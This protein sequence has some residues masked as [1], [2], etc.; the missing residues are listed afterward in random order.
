[1]ESVFDIKNVVSVAMSVKT[2]KTPLIF[3]D[4]TF[5]KFGK[6]RIT[7]KLG[8]VKF[9]LAPRDFF[10]LNP[11]QT[12]ALYDE[13]KKIITKTNSKKIVDCYCGTGTIGQYV[14]TKNTEIR[15]M[16]TIKTA[17]D[18][19][20]INAKNNDIKNFK[21]EVGDAKMW[22]GKWHNE[23][24]DPD[25][26]IVDPPRTGLGKDLINTIIKAK[27][28]TLI[29]VSCNPSTLAKDLKFLKKYYNVQNIQP[30]DMF[31]QTSHVESVVELRRR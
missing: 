19:A 17:I 6:E 28:K 27:P 14:A 24:F 8:H 16:D 22:L 1:M 7:E 3:G 2:D 26:I 23:G 12:I 10:Q 31:P 13:V 11:V 5:V 20:K 18:S 15:G 30:V 29:Y 25:T 9:N 21:Y 4:K